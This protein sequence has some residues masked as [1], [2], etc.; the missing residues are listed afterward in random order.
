MKE[1]G[2]DFMDYSS[3]GRTEDRIKMLEGH[4]R[5]QWRSIEMLWN[6]IDFTKR[7]NDAFER[8]MLICI[9]CLIC[10]ILFILVRCL[11]LP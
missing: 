8:N 5:E 10:I 11:M 7:S 3:E 1:D 2:N 4:I 9:I 6:E